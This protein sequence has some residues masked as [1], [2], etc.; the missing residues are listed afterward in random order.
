MEQR[1]PADLERRGSFHWAWIILGTCFVNLFINYSI[2]LGYGVLLPEM[3]GDL[4]FSRTAGGSIYNAYFLS[5]VALTPVAGYL[6]DRIGARRVIT[7]CAGILGIM[8]WA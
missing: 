3:I 6:T 1:A 5:Y 8:Y 7:A 4:G 2:R